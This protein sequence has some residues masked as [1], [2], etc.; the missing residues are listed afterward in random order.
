MIAAG[1]AAI[2]DLARLFEPPTK[3]LGVRVSAIRS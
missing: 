3:S 2:R 1:E